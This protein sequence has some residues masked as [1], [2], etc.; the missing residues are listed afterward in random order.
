MACKRR[1]RSKPRRRRSRRSNS[2][3]RT[4]AGLAAVGIGSAVAIRVLRDI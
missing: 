3:V 1:K 2:P 4:A